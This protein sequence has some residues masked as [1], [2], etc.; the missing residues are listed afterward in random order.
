MNKTLLCISLFLHSFAFS[1]GIEH[2]MD[3]FFDTFNVKSNFNTPEYINS[4]LGVHFLGGS[5]VIRTPVYDVNPIHIS[6]PKISAG[7]GGIDYTLGGLNIASKDEMKK[8]LKSIASNGASYAFLLGLETVSPVIS[9]NLK[10]VQ[11]WANQLNAININSCELATSIVQGAWPKNQRASSHICEHASTSNPLF[12]DLI[13]AKHGCR[14]TSKQQHIVDK[15]QKENKNLLIG[16]YNI[17][18]K[19]LENTSHDL[20]TKNL[21]MTMTGTIVVYQHPGASSYS[22]TFQPKYEKAIDLLRFGGSLSDAYLIE[23]DQIGVKIGELKILPEKG[24]KNKVYK[25]LLSLQQ[26]IIEENKNNKVSLSEEEKS[27]I[28]GTHFPIGSLLSLMAQYN[29][30][31]GML[32]IE[33]YADLIAY[34]HVIQFVERVVK[35]TLHHAEALREAQV[36]AEKLEDYIKSIQR[37]L[38]DLQALNVKN[39]QNISVEHQLIDYLM[40]VDRNL[41]ERER[42]L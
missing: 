10:Q 33:R 34:D 3:K 36:S 37:I 13:E 24:W 41:K 21:L 6:L 4:Q 11:T 38:Q 39:L 25:I 27:L 9:S 12:T 1:G 28:S 14:D 26:K 15:L 7:C 18:W 32:A 42:G 2:Q 30:K 35:D 8:A 5:S 19:A 40:N 16:N 31:G 22:K 23:N 29:G 17:A 20:E